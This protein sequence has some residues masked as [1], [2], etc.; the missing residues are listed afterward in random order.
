[1][2]TITL[3]LT[4]LSLQ[5]FAFSEYEITENF[6]KLGGDEDA[7]AQALCFYSRYQGKKFKRKIDGKVRRTGKTRIT[8]RDYIAIADLTKT[9]DF[10]RFF[11]V[12]L[13][14]SEVRAYYSTH[15]S[16]NED[17]IFNEPLFA[18]YFSNEH[19]SNLTPRGFHIS[20]ERI[21]SSR[22]WKWHM[23]LDGVEAGVND[24]S[25]DRTVV[26]HSGVASYDSNIIKVRPGIASSNDED[27][28]LRDRLGAQAMSNGCT[29]VSK[30]HSE[31]I[32]AATG[33][34][35]LFYNFTPYEKEQGA[36]YCGSE[37]LL[38]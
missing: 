10:K 22:G 12:N 20:G 25:R 7:I 21:A 16:G 29:T 31:Q 13:K 34:G 2:K 32:Y 15:G 26:F 9:S 38:R 17:D 8:N 33:E 35:T 14:T 18:E 28:V 30:E 37:R 4:L 6:T 1:M 27:P 23:K 19:N 36:Y 11:L 3:L 24:N 5:S